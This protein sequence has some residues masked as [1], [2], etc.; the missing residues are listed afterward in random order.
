MN[1]SA[2][3]GVFF[4][5]NE[6][7]LTIK[8]SRG[9]DVPGGHTKNGETVGQTIIREAYEEAGA[10]IKNIQIVEKIQTKTGMYRDQN[11]IFVTGKVVSFDIKRAKLSSMTVFLKEYTQKK[12]LMR[13]VLR[14]AK[15][16]Y[17][18]KRFAITS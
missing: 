6:N 10:V 11:M 18:R 13:K 4:D 15:N 9:I 14:K 2:V 5:Q 8:N 17:E 7:L 3:I 16:V 12:Q 1:T